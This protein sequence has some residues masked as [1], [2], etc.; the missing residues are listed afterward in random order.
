MQR[1]IA[2]VFVGE[3][4]TAFRY[5]GDSIWLKH[6]VA[7]T[8]GEYSADGVNDLATGQQGLSWTFW[9]INPG[10][11]VGGVLLEDWVTVDASKMAFIQSA[12][13]PMLPTY[14]P[15]PTSQPS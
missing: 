10:G 2:P 6:W 9:A 1:N 7:Y 15:V 13:A 14:D 8:N 4:G 11:D 5:P 3:Y 12:L